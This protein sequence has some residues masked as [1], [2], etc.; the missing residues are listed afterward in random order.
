M[1]VFAAEGAARTFDYQPGDVGIVPKNMGHFVE[2]VGDEDVEMLEIFRADEFRDFSLFQ[3]YVCFSS[4]SPSFS[5][6]IIFVFFFEL[7]F[8]WSG[9]G[10]DDRSMADVEWCHRL[11]ETPRQMVVDTLFKGDKEAGKK[12]LEKIEDA[13][14]D[15]ITLPPKGYD[16][17]DTNEGE[18]DL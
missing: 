5:S 17:T 15:E 2:N 14:K 12:F 16:Q 18:E 9:C 1:T 4:F 10:C 11:G 13:G 3:W 7:G 6:V 8:E